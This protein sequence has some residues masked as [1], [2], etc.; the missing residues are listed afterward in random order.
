MTAEPERPYVPGVEDAAAKL[1]SMCGLLSELC[2][3]HEGIDDP[4]SGSFF[5]LLNLA[6][7]I[8]ADLGAAIKA[9]QW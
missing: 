2:N 6:E 5:S 1:H 9:R 4:A 8:H 3:L 7:H